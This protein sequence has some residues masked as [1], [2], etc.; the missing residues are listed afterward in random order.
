MR[1]VSIIV[2]VF[3]S[4]NTLIRCI[5]SILQQNYKNFE[6]VVV[7]DGSTDN[8]LEIIKSYDLPFMFFFHQENKGACAARNLGIDKSTGY[9]IKFLD[10]DDFLEPSSLSTQVEVA[11]SVEEK[12][13]PYGYRNVL[14]GQ[15]QSIRKVEISSDNQEVELILNNLITSLPLHRKSALASVNFF[16]ESLKFRQE[17]DLHLRLASNGYIFQY[18]DDCVF[19][20]YLHDTEDRI[21][22]RKLNVHNEIFNLNEIRSKFNM[23]DGSDVASAWSY[24]YWTLGRQFLKK[25]NNK[26]AQLLFNLAKE[27]SPSNY[28][29]YQPFLYRFSSSFFGVSFS[30]K[31]ILMYKKIASLF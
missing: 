11:E 17:W 4:S 24:I 23:V 5:N 31:L 25:H 16:D 14:N 21:S 22:S 9:Y 10:S 6:I 7:D 3:N 19:T 26:D 1:K 28:K 30:E 29:N 27:I 18:H 12:V 20:Q 2:P 13:I 15:D 8:S